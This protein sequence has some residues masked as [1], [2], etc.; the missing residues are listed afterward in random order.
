[1]KKLIALIMASMLCFALAVPVSASTTQP[2]EG[3]EAYMS[4]T[5][6]GLISFD[7]AGAIRNGFS[8]DFVARCEARAKAMNDLVLNGV[9]TINPDFTARVYLGTTRSNDTTYVEYNMWG[10]TVYYSV[11][12]TQKIVNSLPSKNTIM[13]VSDIF[14]KV[15]STAGLAVAG[16]TIYT[17]AVRQAASNGTGIYVQIYDDGTTATPLC[18]IGPR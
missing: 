15:S 9:T 17:S 12:D 13:K 5:D 14:S 8:P 1:M 7:A 10:Y 6:Q 16:T 2:A 4:L 3:L 11:A 18:F